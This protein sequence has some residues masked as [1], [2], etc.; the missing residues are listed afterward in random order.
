MFISHFGRIGQ[1]TKYEADKGGGTGEPAAQPATPDEENPSG[2]GKPT[3]S[4]GHASG[5]GDVLPQTPEE[6]RAL[7]NSEADRRVNKQ[8]ESWEQTTQEAIAE[9]VKKAAERAQMSEKERLE[10][11]RKELEAKQA[12]ENAQLKQQLATYK[13]KSLLAGKGLPTDDTFIAAFVRDDDQETETAINAFK[14]AFDEAVK[15]EVTKRMTGTKTPAAGGGAAVATKKPDE[16]TIDELQ[17]L[18][19]ADPEKYKAIMAQL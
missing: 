4:D 1:L 15:N 18:F 12:A 19:K 17:E 8:K 6:L 9:A 13:A 16:Y 7:I 11:E 5:Q 14:S 2:E 10:A 3:G